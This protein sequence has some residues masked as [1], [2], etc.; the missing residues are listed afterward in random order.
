MSRR[1]FFSLVAVAIAIAVG[2]VAAKIY[3]ALQERNAR[4]QAAP[5]QIRISADTPLGGPFTLTN[6]DGQ[7]V[8]EIDFRGRF[9]LV[10][11]GYTYCPDVC[12]T[13]L[14]TIALAMKTLGSEAR[15]VVPIFITVDP[16][17]DTPTVLKTYLA[18]FGSEFVGLT[19][20]LQEIAAAAQAYRVYYKKEAE[21]S[22]P[23]NYSVDHTSLLYLMGKN[24][25]IV[26]LFRTGA[27]PDDLAAGIRAAI[28]M[29]S[30]ATAG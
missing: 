13:E 10:Y 22:D 28:T 15:E 4:G 5:G 27:T 17:R 21:G 3:F 2:V 11:F 18:S 14:N 8:T 20:S 25:K 19:G 12:P 7:R 30:T 24:G 6:Q 9:M 26:A 29:S 16:E 23:E 1:V